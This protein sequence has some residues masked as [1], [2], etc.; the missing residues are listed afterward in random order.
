MGVLVLVKSSLSVIFAWIMPLE[1]YLRSRH[2]AQSHLPY[3]LCNFPG[4]LYSFALYIKVC[5]PFEWIFLKGVRSVSRLTFSCGCPAA[6]A[7]FLENALCSIALPLLFVEDRCTVLVQVYFCT[8]FCTTDLFVLLPAPQCLG[9]CIFI[10]SLEVRWCDVS[11]LTLLFFNAGLALLD[12]LLLHMSI[13]ISFSI[14][15]K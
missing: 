5:D 11:P 14:Y 4:V 3:L 7:P 1:L 2:H 10:V 15:R 13:R 12:L 6:P 8:P 9:Y